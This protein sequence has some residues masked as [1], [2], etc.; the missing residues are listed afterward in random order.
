MTV[1]YELPTAADFSVLA[2]AH[3]PAVTIYASTSPVVSERERAEVAVKSGFDEALEH[4]KAAGA[5]TAELDAIRAERDRILGDQQLW[6]GLARSLA[7]FVSPDVSEVFVLPNRLDDAVHVGSHFTLGQLLR[8]PS[9]DQEAFAITISAS[10]WALWHATPTDRAVKLPIDQQGTAN[11]D[12]ATNREPGEDKPRGSN[13]G[14]AS[15]FGGASR[16]LGDEGRKTLLDQYTKRVIEVARRELLERD[17]D[18]R[19]PVFVFAA[20]PLLSLFLQNTR[21]SRRVVAVPGSPDRLGAAELDEILRRELG[22]LNVR[23]AER[24]LRALAEGSAGRVERDLAAI[25]REAA[26]GAVETFWFDFTT[27]V[28]GTLDRESGAIE[29]ATDHGAGDALADGTPAGDLLPQLALL[30]VSKGGKVVTVRASELDGG[31][32]SAPAMAELRFALA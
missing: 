7:L 29:F 31:V 16:L 9:Q 11:L 4:L 3:H 6:G 8:A 13:R 14:T 12:E 10:E 19:V 21:N 23:E 15:Q 32:W 25:A 20:E 5:D 24:A 18:E 22:R 26:D 28:N 30:V 27:S 2:G 17:P 1:H